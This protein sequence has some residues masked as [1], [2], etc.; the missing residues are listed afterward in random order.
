[1]GQKVNPISFRLQYSKKWKSMW[2]AGKEDYARFLHEDLKLREAVFSILGPK[3]GIADVRIERSANEINIFLSTSRPGVIIGRGGT[4]A[5]DLKKKLQKFATDKIKDISITEVKNPELNARLIGDNIVGQLEKR[6]AFKRAMRQSVE[7]ALK[8]GAKG[9][10]IMIAGRLNGA[11]IARREFVSR[12]KIPLQTIK[13]D[14][15][16]AYL[17]AKTTYG[18]LGVKVWVY[19]GQ[20]IDRTVEVKKAEDDS[21]VGGKR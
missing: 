10:K 8:A 15:D 18:I 17:R 14:V 3:G 12:G 11:E 21:I 1:M 16:Y 4:G 5:V 2:F 19:K 13:A 7:R 6:I 20:D 9:I